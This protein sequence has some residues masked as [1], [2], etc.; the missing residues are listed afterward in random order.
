MK[1]NKSYKILLFISMILIIL[2]LSSCSVKKMAVNAIAKNMTG[3]DTAEVFL[4]DND[5]QLVG[6]SLPLVLK[7]MD[8]LVS[9]DPEN[10]NI[11]SNAGSLFVM[12]G[13]FYIQLPADM[14]PYDQWQEQ[15]DMYARAKKHY[16]RGYDYI[17]RA[18]NMRHKNFSEEMSAG[19]FDQA[20]ADMK[21]SDAADLYWCSAAVLAGCSVDVLDPVF[22]A[23]RGDAVRMLF[24]AYELDPDFGSGMIDELMMLYYA[25]MPAGMGGDME[26]AVW[27][28][29]RGIEISDDTLLSLYVSYATSICT[30][31]QTRE[32]YDEFAD[33]LEKVLERDVETSS[34]NRLTNIVSQKK[35]AWLLENIDNYFLIGF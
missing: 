3:N 18:L 6:D 24:K 33:M 21:K 30:K 29:R 31:N 23:R 34:A 7:M 32:G 5:P 26:K 11:L 10:P 19:N 17:M 8:M 15:K 20:F 1:F 28:F 4:S 16:N 12:Y 14:L 35:A 2:E 25:S 13:N 22:A 27:H 9:M